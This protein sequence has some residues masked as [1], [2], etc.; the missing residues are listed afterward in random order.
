M[1]RTKVNKKK[2][3]K[4]FKHLQSRTRNKKTLPRGGTR[5]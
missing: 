3:A 2:D 1:K 4:I 5:L